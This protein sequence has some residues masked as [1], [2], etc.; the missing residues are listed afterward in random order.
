MEDASNLYYLH[1]DAEGSK[2]IYKPWFIEKIYIMKSKAMLH[3]N[4]K[5]V[6]TLLQNERSSNCHYLYPDAELSKDKSLL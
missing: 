1:P 6:R 5:S 3:H 2:H 4:D